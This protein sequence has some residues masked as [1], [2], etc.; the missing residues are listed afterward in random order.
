MIL[1]WALAAQSG[2]STLAQ[3]PTPTTLQNAA[4]AT[5]NGTPLN[6]N[7]P[8]GNPANTLGAAGIQIIG[9]GTWVVTFEVT[10]DGTNWTAAMA[11]N[12]ADDVRD[13]TASAAGHYTILYG[14][15]VS[16]RAR[17]SSYTSGSVTAK[18]RLIPGLV[19][20]VAS[21]G[22]GSGTVNSGVGGQFAYYPSTGTTV[23]D[24]SGFAYS[25]AAD[26][27]LSATPASGKTGLVISEPTS[28]PPAVV[29]LA[30]ALLNLHV[31]NS[32]TYWGIGYTSNG[33]AAQ[34]ANF[35]ANDGGLQFSVSGVADG[36]FAIYP[37]GITLASVSATYFGGVAEVASDQFGLMLT[38]STPTSGATF[39]LTWRDTGITQ[40]APAA[41][42]ADGDLAVNHAHLYLNETADSLNVK[43]KE[44]GGTVFTRPISSLAAS[45]SSS[46]AKT[47]DTT[48]AN[49]TG[50]TRNVEAGRTYT[51]RAE[52]DTTAAV[53]GGVKFAVSGTATATSINYS[54][55]LLDGTT[56]LANTRA[57][58]LNTTVCAVT[59]STA[60]TCIIKGTIVVNAAG[61]LTLQFAQNASDAGASTVLVNQSLQLIPIN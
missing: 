9:S 3:T 1:A 46:F 42:L 43:W 5:G 49:I 51:F 18:G 50:L 4:T 22:G 61:T 17:V 56:V 52:L 16:V 40:L 11:T 35:L 53:T 19:S 27:T 20:R 25:A 28:T 44:A 15:A 57:T 6:I 33:T 38:A 47:T 2:I 31:L 29:Q 41:A 55:V 59:T 60:G 23:D 10:T 58:A 26:A 13:T 36:D 7:G 8:A 12:L 54:G 39:P 37:Q 45:N 21:S 34:W 48:L 24:V 32:S 30:P 14:S